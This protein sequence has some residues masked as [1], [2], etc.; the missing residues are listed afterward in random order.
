MATKQELSDFF[1]NADAE[2]VASLAEENGIIL[3]IDRY[4]EAY[5]ERDPDR[6]YFYS[7]E[8]HFSDNYYSFGLPDIFRINSM[9]EREFNALPTFVDSLKEKIEK[10]TSG[11]D[12]L[13][14]NLNNKGDSQLLSDIIH[15]IDGFTA[16]LEDYQKKKQTEKQFEHIPQQQDISHKTANADLS[17]ARGE[18]QD[19]GAFGS[20][21]EQNATA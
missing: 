4:R 13:S 20:D 5:E 18:Q 3:K 16:A 17:A 7:V 1:N 9:G 14:I 19:K 12:P 8:G 11:K 21:E 6:G 2:K 10:L 15:R